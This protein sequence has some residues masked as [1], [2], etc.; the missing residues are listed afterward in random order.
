MMYYGG[1]ERIREGATVRERQA[2]I[3]IPRHDPHV[4]ERQNSRKLH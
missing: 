3:T 1:E 2:I 4:R